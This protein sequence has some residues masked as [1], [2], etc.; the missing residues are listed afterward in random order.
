VNLAI[1]LFFLLT[2]NPDPGQCQPRL[3]A[4]VTAT[5]YCLTGKTTSGV[6]TF[7]GCIALSRDL[8]QDLN[9]EFGDLVEVEGLGQFVFADLMPPQWR[10]RVDIYYPTLRQCRV[11][12]VKKLQIRIIKRKP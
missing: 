7:P 12:G 8:A 10:R 4:R 1:L 3:T 6:R 9:A 11:F 2:L 5:A